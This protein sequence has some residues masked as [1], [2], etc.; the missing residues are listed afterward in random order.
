[1]RILSLVDK[2][3]LWS[4]E[5]F[6]CWQVFLL[7]A[8][9]SP[10]KGLREEIRNRLGIILDRNI[11][12]NRLLRNSFR[13][14]TGENEYQETFYGKP[15][16]AIALKKEFNWLWQTIH[17]FDM[18]FA[19]KFAPR[20][21]LGFDTLTKYP[22]AHPETN[23]FDGY[24]S[25]SQ[26]PGAWAS[27]IALNGQSVDDTAQTLILSFIGNNFCSQDQFQQVQRGFALFDT[28]ALT[29]DATISDATFSPKIWYRSD[30]YGGVSIEIVAATTASN[31]G[32]TTT[33]LENTK[34]NGTT[35]F[36]N[37][38]YSAMTTGAYNDFVFNSSGKSGV[39]KT[40]ITKLGTMSGWEFSG[41]FGGTWAASS[42][43]QILARSADLGYDQSK[44][45]ITYTL[46]VTF[47]PQIII[48]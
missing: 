20:F 2:P 32:S 17:R 1:M 21:N 45:I 7:I 31:T 14:K 47:V 25:A 34:T 23:T 41:T 10:F 30:P 43:G 37:L 27:L 13:I 44:L 24:I 5:W 39:N 29:T 8:V 35:S 4:N 6:E 33:D 40:G 48:S 26:S 42:F 46:P 12:V 3:K 19:N 36:C 28:S 15:I 11:L 16:F 18:S 9:N 38:A 22:D